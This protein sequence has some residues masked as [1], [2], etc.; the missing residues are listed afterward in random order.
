MDGC[1]V[2]PGVVPEYKAIDIV[3]D[4]FVF[5]GAEPPQDGSVLLACIRLGPDLRRWRGG[6]IILMHYA[7]AGSNGIQLQEPGFE[8]RNVTLPLGWLP[9]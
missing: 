6:K 3:N 1:K 2:Y 4:R 9:H 7:E 5:E 8:P